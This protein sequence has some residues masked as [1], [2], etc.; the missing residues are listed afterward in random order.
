MTPGLG[1]PGLETRGYNGTKPAFAGY[2]APSVR[3]GMRR[4]VRGRTKPVDE[5]AKA[6]FEL[7][8]PGVFNPGIRRRAVHPGRDAP[9]STLTST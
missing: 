7:F 3:F 2:A 8:Q 4:C 1:S 6:D 9:D 5:S